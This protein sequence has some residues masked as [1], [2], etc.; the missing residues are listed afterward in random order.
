MQAT[1]DRLRALLR[2]LADDDRILLEHRIVD[3]W[4]YADIAVRLAMPRGVLVD[5]VCRL[6]MDLRPN[7][8]FRATGIP[9]YLKNKRTL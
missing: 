2:N 9:A 6:R 1:S 5:R 4:R 3:G 8:T 7:H